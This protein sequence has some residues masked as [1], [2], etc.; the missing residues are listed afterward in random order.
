[1]FFL[2]IFRLWKARAASACWLQTLCVDSRLFLR[3]DLTAAASQTPSNHW[4]SLPPT[5]CLL[6][7]PP[8]LPASSRLWLITVPVSSPHS[9]S[10]YCNTPL[11]T[12]VCSPFSPFCC[13]VWK[14]LSLWVFLNWRQQCCLVVAVSADSRQRVR[15]TLSFCWQHVWLCTVMLPHHYKHQPYLREQSY[16]PSTRREKA[17]FWLKHVKVMSFLFT[18]IQNLILGPKTIQTSVPL[19]RA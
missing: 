15:R 18:M 9:L 8:H 1:M 6:T 13:S 17:L 2:F 19:L 16:T 12:A 3:S 4:A 7:S 14:C 10:H 5:D 11:H